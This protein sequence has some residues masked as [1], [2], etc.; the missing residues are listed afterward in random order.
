MPESSLAAIVLAAGA[1]TRLRP[2]THLLPKVL[3]PVGNVALLDHA[4]MRAAAVADAV[5]VNVH[6]GADAITEHVRGRAHVSLEREQAL[7]TAGAVGLLRPWIAGRD[8]L[9]LNGDTWHPQTLD[10]LV[11]G[12]DRER[13]RLVGVR[14][15]KRPD[16]GPYRYAG[17][18]LLPFRIAARL[19]PERLSL[20]PAVFAP[21]N[22]EGSLDMWESRIPA[23]DCGTLRSYVAANVAGC[24][25]G[26]VIAGDARVAGRVERSVIGGGAEIRGAVSDSVVWPGATV[27]P[28]ESLHRAVRAA[29]GFTVHVRTGTGGGLPDPSLAARGARP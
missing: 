1:G 28:E 27:R 15:E 13:V 29:D 9:V 25:E 5:A 7:E 10:G 19:P 20:Y 22:A 24:A 23:F 17:A 18:A 3:C 16:F 2:L 4:L 26:P 14:D 11:S 12:W 21:A 6:H 8:V